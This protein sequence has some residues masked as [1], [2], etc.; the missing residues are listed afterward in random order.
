MRA[1][2]TIVL[3]GAMVAPCSPAAAHSVDVFA[4]QEK[5][6][7]A[8]RRAEMQEIQQ[9]I[10]RREERRQQHEIEHPSVI[11]DDD[12]DDDLDDA[13]PNHPHRQ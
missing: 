13:A 6:Q 10:E 4:V 8:A 5:Q 3:A 11:D 7:H 9:R 12:D 2:C 1:L